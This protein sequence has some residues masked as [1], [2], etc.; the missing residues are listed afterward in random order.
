MLRSIVLHMILTIR[1]QIKVS[2]SLLEA[3]LNGLMIPTFPETFAIFSETC[4]YTSMHIDCRT[5]MV[6]SVPECSYFR[7]LFKNF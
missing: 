5:G 1:K 3:L 6:V 7:G 2:F 4:E